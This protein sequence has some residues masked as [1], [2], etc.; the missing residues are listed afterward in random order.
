MRTVAQETAFHRALRNCSRDVGKRSVLYMIL[1]KRGCAV[2]NTFYQKLA[3]SHERMSPLMI[4]VLFQMWRDA[5]TGLIKSPE[6]TCL[7]ACSAS[8]SKAQSASFLISTL[9]SFQDV[10]KIGDYSSLWFN[11]CI[12]SKCQFL[13]DTWQLKPYHFVMLD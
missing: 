7:K 6:N 12:G 11:P 3:A 13:C 4:L 5:R 2:K 10:L 1:V 9:N 8:F